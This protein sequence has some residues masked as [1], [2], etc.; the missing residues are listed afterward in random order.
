MSFFFSLTKLEN[1]EGR[2]VPAGGIDTSGKGEDVRK[3][4]RKVD[5]VQILYRPVCKWKNDTC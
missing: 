1:R 5:T 3:G 4:C 2:A